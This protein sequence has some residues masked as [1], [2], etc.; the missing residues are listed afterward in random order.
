MRRALIVAI[1]A[2]A[3]VPQALGGIAEVRDAQGRLIANGGE[4]SFGSLN[5]AGWTLRYD[6]AS[7]STGGGLV[8]GVS[9]GG[10]LVYADRVFVPAHGLR[11]ARVSG[12]LVNGHAVRATPNTLV[13]LGP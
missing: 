2:L 9:L 4:G 7:S 5:D 10:G 1:V 6:S 3:V 13:P 8:R 12:L 11:G